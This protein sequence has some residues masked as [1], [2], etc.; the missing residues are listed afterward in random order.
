MAL[1]DVL[2]P[3]QASDLRIV[4]PERPGVQQKT[5]STDLQPARQSGAAFQAPGAHH[6][7]ESRW[8]QG[9]S[10]STASLEKPSKLVALGTG[11]A[12][13]RSVDRLGK[14]SSAWPANG[15]SPQTAQSTLASSP[16]AA[17]SA[18]AT[19]PASA[20]PGDVKKAT[21]TPPPPA[22][23]PPLPSSPPPPTAPSDRGSHSKPM[24]Q[25]MKMSGT[26]HNPC[27]AQKAPADDPPAGAAPGSA[28][29]LRNSLQAEIERRQ[30]RRQSNPSRL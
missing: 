27:D 23:P 17:A 6:L 28:A 15:L 4:C 26:Q 21:P 11:A 16:T 13:V 12:G 18:P 8:D 3:F 19:P 7:P 9:E 22:P 24:P 1:Q 29:H 14:H 10:M 2:V 30:K 5:G 20:H 25:A